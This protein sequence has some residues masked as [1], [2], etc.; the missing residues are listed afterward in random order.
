[1]RR[2][3]G[4]LIGSSWKSSQVAVVCITLLN[5]RAYRYKENYALGVF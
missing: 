5:A 2:V 3:V 1:M 4:Y